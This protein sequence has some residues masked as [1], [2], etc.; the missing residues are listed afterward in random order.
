LRSD[1]RL[2]VAGLL[3]AVRRG[4]VTI[5]NPLGS[6]V[7]ENA[8][9]LAFLPKLAQHF[10]GEDLL[11]PSV[12]TWWCGQ[13]RERYF[14]FQN[15]EHL[16]IKQINRRKENTYWVGNALS[17]E[18]KATLRVINLSLENPFGSDPPQFE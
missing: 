4:N 1:S 17:N 15:L 2:G 11:L 6:S 12:A 10:L 3:E 13:P 8:G 5:A 7:L 9:L 14:V 16:V 18:Q